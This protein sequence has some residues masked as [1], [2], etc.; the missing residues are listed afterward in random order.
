MG[1]FLSNAAKIVTFVSRYNFH[2]VWVRSHLQKSMISVSL[3]SFL[4][5]IKFSV[6]AT[7]L[8]RSN[9]VNFSCA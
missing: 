7:N 1:T 8:E 6:V 9:S 2:L 4:I 3:T 5:S